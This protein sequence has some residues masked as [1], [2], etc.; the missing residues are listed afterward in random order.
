MS[1]RPREK[2]GRVLERADRNVHT[3]A[4]IFLMHAEQ[5][6]PRLQLQPEDRSFCWSKPSN[7]VNKLMD[8][9]HRVHD[10]RLTGWFKSRSRPGRKTI[11]DYHQISSDYSETSVASSQKTDINTSEQID[12]TAPWSPDDMSSKASKERHAYIKPKMEQVLSCP[13]T[14]PVS[15]H[16]PRPPPDNPPLT[17]KYGGAVTK[18]RPRFGSTSGT[19]SYHATAS[20]DDDDDD[21][22]SPQPPRPSHPA[23]LQSQSGGNPPTTSRPRDAARSQLRMMNPSSH[24]T[25]SETTMSDT[26]LPSSTATESYHSMYSSSTAATVGTPSPRTSRLSSSTN[27]RY[28]QFTAATVATSTPEDYSPDTPMNSM[29]APHR[30]SSYSTAA[31]VGTSSPRTSRLSSSTDPRYSETVLQ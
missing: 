13:D 23:P 22:D 19:T 27:P 9:S 2:P 31:T 5:D 1:S 8:D 17:R 24:I 11:E 30:M 10:G 3:G 25:A 15:T 16:P 26:L 14:F 21:D 29:A 6:N 12:L 20:D 7:N 18:W 4:A 28:S